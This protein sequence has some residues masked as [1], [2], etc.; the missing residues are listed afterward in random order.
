[1]DQQMN[2]LPVCDCKQASHDHGHRIMYNRHKCR[3]DDCRKA[4]RVYESDR[5]RQQAYGRSPYT[6][7][8]RVRERI[9]FLQKNGLSFKQIAKV[10]GV[11]QSSISRVIYG[12][13]ERGEGPAKRILKT[14][15]EKILAVVPTLE[16][17]APS[18]RIN[19]TGTRRRLQALVAVGWSMSK[20]GERLGCTQANMWKIMSSRAEVEAQTA[21]TVR[22]LYD[23]LWDQAPPMETRGDKASYTKSINLAKAKGWPL[24]M[25]WDDDKIDNPMCRVKRIMDEAA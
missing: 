12:R 22:A 1:M 25:D 3:C 20:L 24:P 9:L 15:E 21:R 5:R 16:N 8:D 13:T 10:S 17:F 23:E 2:T 4:N 11:P 19:G 14:S 6:T 7:T 18:R